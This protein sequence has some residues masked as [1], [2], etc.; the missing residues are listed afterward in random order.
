DPT[1]DKEAIDEHPDDSNEPAND[2]EGQDEL[3][4]RDADA[5][6]IKIMAAEPPQEDPQ[7]IRDRWDLLVGLE[8]DQ[9]ARVVGQSAA[10]AYLVPYTGGKVSHGYLLARSSHYMRRLAAALNGIFCC[11]C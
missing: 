5:P 10:L 1:W 6:Q 11:R 9:H 3:G 8:K 4:H 2:G 7:D